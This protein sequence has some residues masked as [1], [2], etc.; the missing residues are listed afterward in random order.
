MQHKTVPPASQL[1]HT[2]RATGISFGA[3]DE[4]MHHRSLAEDKAMI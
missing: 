1:I 3:P 4:A 2:A